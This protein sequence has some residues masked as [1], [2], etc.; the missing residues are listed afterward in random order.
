MI[1]LNGVRRISKFNDRT[2]VGQATFLKEYGVRACQDRYIK[3]RPKPMAS[4]SDKA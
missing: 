1:V 3:A 2:A 4:L